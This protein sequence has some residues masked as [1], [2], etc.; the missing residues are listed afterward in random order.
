ME[1]EMALSSWAVYVY[2]GK[3]GDTHACLR[4]AHLA[5]KCAGRLARRQRKKETA[6]E[7]QDALYHLAIAKKQLVCV[8]ETAIEENYTLDKLSLDIAR[9]TGLI[10]DIKTGGYDWLEVM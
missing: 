5:K 4:H 7:L 3:E 9:K 6:N 1:D 10:K 8:Q 2:Y